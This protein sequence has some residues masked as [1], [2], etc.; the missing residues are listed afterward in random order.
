MN[1]TNKLQTLPARRS[2]EYALWLAVEIGNLAIYLGQQNQLDSLGYRQA[3]MADDMVDTNPVAM[4]LAFGHLR[5]TCKFLPTTGEILEVYAPIAKRLRDE[6][7]TAQRIADEQAMKAQREA[8][9]QD[10]ISDADVTADVAALAE[11]ATIAHRARHAA[12][13]ITMPAPTVQD[14][15]HCGKAIPTKV[16]DLSALSPADLRSMADR[17]EAKAAAVAAAGAAVLQESRKA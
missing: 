12:Q 11:K 3:Q 10:F 17:R 6:A 15:P 5:R 14:C 7:E 16:A 1:G 2:T 4:Y 13:R 9:P 8:H